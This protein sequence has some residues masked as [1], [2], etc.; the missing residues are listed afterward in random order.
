[1]TSSDR[2]AVLDVLAGRRKGRPP[3]FSGLASVVVP[4]LESTGLAFHQIHDD[5]ERMARA[6]ETSL[7]RFGFASVT[8]P[9]DLG[10]EASALGA[11]V[12]FHG[13]VPYPV[14]PTLKQPLAGDPEDLRLEVPSN[15]AGHGRV[16]VVLEAIRLLK[17]RAGQEAAVGAWVPGPYTLALQLVSM[18]EMITAVAREP[19]AVGKI[20]DELTEVVAAVALA[21]REAGADFITVHEMGG[22]PGFIG[23]RAF[24]E[25]VQ[26]RLQRLLAALPAPRVLSICGSTNRAMPLLAACGADALSVDQTNN[27]ARSRETLGPGV[28]LFGNIDPVGVLANG[29]E[30]AVR[31]AVRRAIEAGVDAV[32]PGCDLA[33]A[34]P[35]ENLRAMV[36]EARK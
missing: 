5:P 10:V 1:L 25:L 8:V 31:A 7:R 27:L 22:S 32:W 3:C 21:Y 24:E 12:D 6:A 18:V 23:P 28:L 13:D 36:D 4:A 9:F 34:I 17:G 11:E 26:P 19:A 29:D 30:A 33:P 14:Y 2:Q 16:P 15:L 20:L 35:L